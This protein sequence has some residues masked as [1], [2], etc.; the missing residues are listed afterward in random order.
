MALT[1]FISNGIQDFYYL[2]KGCL[3]T[4]YLDGSLL[5]KEKEKEKRN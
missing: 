4:T 5:K 1:L 2:C 3:S